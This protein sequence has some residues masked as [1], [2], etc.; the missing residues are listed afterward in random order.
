[1]YWQAQTIP[2]QFNREKP[3]S[4]YPS[5]ALGDRTYRLMLAKLTSREPKKTGPVEEARDEIP[6]GELY[7]PGGPERGRSS[8]SRWRIHS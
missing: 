3:F 2:P 1:M 8:T 6:W 4:C 7:T 5:K